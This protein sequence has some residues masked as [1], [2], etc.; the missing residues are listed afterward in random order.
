MY[1]TGM[2]PVPP[3][4]THH[5]NAQIVHMRVFSVLCL[6]FTALD[7]FTHRCFHSKKA[8]KNPISGS[9]DIH[10]RWF[11]GSRSPRSKS[12]VPK[13]SPRLKPA[14]KSRMGQRSEGMSCCCCCFT[15]RK[16]K[17]C[18]ST[19]EMTL[20]DRRGVFQRTMEW[21]VTCT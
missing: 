6:L 2:F 3:T 10:S 14:W 8:N 16:E 21:N 20:V 12:S 19:R 13:D 18:S 11:K 9:L 4:H 17:V 1:T 15:V 5:R 7:I